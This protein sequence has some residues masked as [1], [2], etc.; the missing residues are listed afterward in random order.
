MNDGA[1]A[2]TIVFIILGSLAFGFVSCSNLSDR[3]A[4]VKST[5]SFIMG[6]ASYKCT[7]T[8]ELKTDG[9]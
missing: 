8:N 3:N 4:E 5:K 6:N 1:I 9:N 7:K 2:S